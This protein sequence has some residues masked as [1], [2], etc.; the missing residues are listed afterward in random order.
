SA[1]SYQVK[2]LEDFVGTALFRREAR[3]V[4]LSEHGRAV[5]PLVRRALGD[6]AQAF[7]SAKT[8]TANLLVIS[9]MHTFATTWLAPRIGSFQMANPDLAVRLDISSHL[10]NFHD[11][12]VDIAIRSGKGIWPGL[13]SHLI[14]GGNF[15]VVCNPLYYERIGRPKTP[16]DLADCIFIGPRDDWWPVWFAAAEIV[17]PAAFK[18]PGVDVE[19]Q[20]MAA[21]LAAAG[22]GLAL[23]HLGFVT[24]EFKAGKLIQPFDV[25][26]SSGF[27]YYLVYADSS[28]LPN[29][30]KLF[31]DWILKEAGQELT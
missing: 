8:E 6:L 15:T 18:R 26:A 5:A 21:V 4:A 16:A 31:R 20:Q 1:V 7:R 14:G 9:T 27:N 11:D 30:T 28:R 3:G 19:T 17:P 29:K 2:L 10:A 25:M 13:T 12:G 23:V 22:H 24:E